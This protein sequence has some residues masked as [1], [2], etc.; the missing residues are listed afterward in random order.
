MIQII[1]MASVF[2]TGVSTDVSIWCVEDWLLRSHNVAELWQ[3]GQEDCH[4]R[5]TTVRKHQNISYLHI[6]NYEHVVCLLQLY[7]DG[8]DFDD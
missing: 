6:K 4:K 3:G 1:W 7:F 5:R 2:V 8:A